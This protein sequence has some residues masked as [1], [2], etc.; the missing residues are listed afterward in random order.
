MKINYFYVSVKARITLIKI[1]Y[2]K[3]MENK[4]KIKR[5]LWILIKI[6]NKNRV[7]F[8]QVSLFKLN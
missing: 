6:N 4:Q 3:K 1:S 5:L 7:I 2:R 8:Y